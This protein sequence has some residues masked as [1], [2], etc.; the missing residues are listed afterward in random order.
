MSIIG[1][2]LTR[3]IITAIFHMEALGSAGKLVITKPKIII[4]YDKKRLDWLQRR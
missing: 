4:I 2:I 1:Y 3:K